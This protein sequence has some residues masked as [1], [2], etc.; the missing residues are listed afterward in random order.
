VLVQAENLK[1]HPAVSAALRRGS[2]EIYGWV[3]HFED[4]VVK[5]YDPSKDAFVSSA[6]V[7]DRALGNPHSLSI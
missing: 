6:E 1:T 5:I 2:I 4:G 7:K 3:Y